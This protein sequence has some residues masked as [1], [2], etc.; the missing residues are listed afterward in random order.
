[1]N[2]SLVGLKRAW[3]HI[4]TKIDTVTTHLNFYIHSHSIRKLLRK[5]MKSQYPPTLVRTLHDL[6]QWQSVDMYMGL[7]HVWINLLPNFDWIFNLFEKILSHRSS[8]LETHRKQK[9]K[10]WKRWSEGFKSDPWHAF[11]SK[12]GRKLV[13]LSMFFSETHWVLWVLDSD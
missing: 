13:F 12:I 10:N 6:V 8:L 1:M 4:I 9:L 11:W 5:R 3:A 2:V 7:M